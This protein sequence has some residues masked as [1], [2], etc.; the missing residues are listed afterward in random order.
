MNGQDMPP[1]KDAEV[2]AALEKLFYGK[3]AY[4]ETFYSV[5]APVDVEHY[6]PKSAVEG[7][8]EDDIVSHPLAQHR[9][10]AAAKI[11]LPPFL[12]GRRTIEAVEC[13]PMPLLDLSAR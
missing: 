9:K 6:R 11:A 2:K 1:P 7:D 8:D 3:C 12:V 4:C 10:E 5:Q 13:I